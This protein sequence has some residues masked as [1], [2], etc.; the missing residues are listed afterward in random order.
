MMVKDKKK[1]DVTK[2]GRGKPDTMKIAGDRDI[3]Y[4]FAM[5]VYREF[6][7]MIKSVILFGSGTK[8][9][10][11]GDSDID[12]LIIIDDV[13]V[14][15]DMELIA[16]Y[17]E[18]L[19]KLIGKNP[20]IKP[21]HINSVK[22]STW[23]NDLLRG[24]P[25][26][27]NVLRYGEALVD[28][29]GFFKPLKVLLHD[30]KIKSTPESLYTLLQRAPGHIARARGFM[31]QSVDGIYWTMIDSAHAALIAHN[32][33]PSSPEHVAEMLHEH[34]VKKKLLHKKYVR[35]YDYVHSVAKKIIHGKLNHVRGQDLDDFM[36]MAEE[37]LNEMARVVD[38]AIE[39]KKS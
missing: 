12:I 33:T 9:S 11:S 10:G 37:F 24:D 36:K 32:L 35:Y 14:N 39:G 17:R 8:K 21:L 23:W 15:W 20:Y 19:G 28:F 27:L 13:S 26:I 3:A 4:D 7:Q 38:I 31:L 2:V 1:K 6:D 18:E 16:W 22:L 30:G 5:K 25:I 29:G 34:F